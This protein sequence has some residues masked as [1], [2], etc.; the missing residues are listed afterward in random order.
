[1]P[2]SQNLYVISR[3]SSISPTPFYTPTYT[4][5]KDEW[6]F[7]ESHDTPLALLTLALALIHSAECHYSSNTVSGEQK[8]QTIRWGKEQEQPVL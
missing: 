1:M 5:P 6:S 8:T 4:A 7:N 3:D 2:T